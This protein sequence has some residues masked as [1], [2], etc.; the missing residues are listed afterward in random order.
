MQQPIGLL[1]DNIDWIQPLLRAMDA[2]GVPSQLIPFPHPPF[3]EFDG[4]A[5]PKVIFN[6][7]AVRTAMGSPGIVTLVRELL[8]ALQL[9]DKHI[10]NNRHCHHVGSSKALQSLVFKHAGVRSPK[11]L[12]LHDKA[13]LTKAREQM[14]DGMLKSNVGG[15]G[16]GV[17]APEFPGQDVPPSI[18]TAAFAADGMAVW[19]QRY[20]P[21][22]NV[23]YRVEMLGGEVLY[24]ARVPVK[25]DS[26]NYCLGKAGSF[27]CPGMLPGAPVTLDHVPET[28]LRSALARI[29]RLADMDVGSVEYL[30]P[31]A[32]SAACFFDINPVSTYHPKAAAFLGFDPYEKLAEWLKAFRQS[33]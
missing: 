4:S 28:E 8:S 23:I 33:N 12:V 26:F 31:N 7:V 29:C 17:W 15:F 32:G 6:R 2:A 25:P 11:T 13:M 1:C 30:I 3:T 24:R 14:P 16:A 22:D 20:I 18:L 27:S 5:Y 19:Q 21:R 10:I 9:Q